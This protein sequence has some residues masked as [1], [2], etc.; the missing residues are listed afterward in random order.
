MKYP[1]QYAIQRGED[2]GDFVIPYKGKGL[3]VIA[4]HGLG[5]EHVSV[6]LPSR[7]PTWE[8]MCFIKDI[9]WGED[10]CVMQLHP[11]KKNYVNNHNYCL[12]LWK[13]IDIQIPQ[14][15]QIMV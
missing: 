2:G 14:P 13:P 12:H 5:W 1:E 6:S 7:C 15:P 10:E 11:P 3:R 4:S 9:F 8:E